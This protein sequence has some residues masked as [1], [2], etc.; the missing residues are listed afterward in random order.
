MRPRHFKA[1]APEIRMNDG[2]RGVILQPNRARQH[3]VSAKC[4]DFSCDREAR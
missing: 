4:V 1:S 2:E 3:A